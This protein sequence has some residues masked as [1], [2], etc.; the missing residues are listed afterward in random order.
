MSMD[1]K[2]FQIIQS[3]I[4]EANN[5]LHNWNDRRAEAMIE[6]D[7]IFIEIVELEKITNEENEIS[8]NTII[9]LRANLAKS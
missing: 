3:Q 5:A 6:L 2:K 1:H 9:G 8:Q 4:Q 7:S